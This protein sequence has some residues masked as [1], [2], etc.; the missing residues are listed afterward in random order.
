MM[1][2]SDTEN[3]FDL[4]IEAAKRLCK[5]QYDEDSDSNAS[6]DDGYGPPGVE[7]STA[8]RV[9]DGSAYEGEGEE[10]RLLGAAA[11]RVLLGRETR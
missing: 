6:T 9:L 2:K 11:A 8:I 4:L 3:D 10:V 7:V 5:T 1:R